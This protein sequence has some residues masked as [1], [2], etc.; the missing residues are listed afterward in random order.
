MKIASDTS[1]TS[2]RT[3]TVSTNTGLKPTSGVTYVCPDY[4]AFQ[5]VISN[6]SQKNLHCQLNS[7]SL[8]CYYSRYL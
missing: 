5:N 6:L 4:N 3:S 2:D 1:D 7:L 8:G